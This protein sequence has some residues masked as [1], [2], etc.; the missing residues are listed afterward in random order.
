MYVRNPGYILE[1]AFERK[2]CDCGLHIREQ[3]RSASL[4]CLAPGWQS[5]SDEGGWADALHLSSSWQKECTVKFEPL[6]YK[7]GG[8]DE[9]TMLF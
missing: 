1:P 6:A 2:K 4:P 3:P 8:G 5:R 7:V 9:H